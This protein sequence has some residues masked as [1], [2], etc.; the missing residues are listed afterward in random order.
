MKLGQKV[1]VQSRMVRRGDYRFKVGGMG[2]ALHKEWI[3]VPIAPRECVV[4]GK[5]TIKNGYIDRHED[6]A[7]WISEKF[8]P[9]FLVVESMNRVPFNV[10]AEDLEPKAAPKEGKP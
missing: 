7:E 10:L 1:T 8:I 5:R 3:S 4:V 9:V 2:K 6:G